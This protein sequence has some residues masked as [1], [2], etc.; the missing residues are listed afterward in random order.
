MKALAWFGTDD[1]RVIE[2]GIPDIVD[3]DDV[4]LV[5]VLATKKKITANSYCSQKVTGST[6]CGSD[7]H[8]YHAEIM[9]LQK[10]DILGHEVRT[11]KLPVFLCVDASHSF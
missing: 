3:P 7:L 4:V 8:L 11:W 10:G 1:V 5:S 2:A 9:G 6:I